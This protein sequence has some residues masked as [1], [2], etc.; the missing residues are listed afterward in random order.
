MKLEA[1]RILKLAGSMAGLLPLPHTD[2]L[3]LADPGLLFE[4]EPQHWWARRI[5]TVVWGRTA[6]AVCRACAFGVNATRAALEL[7]WQQCA[8]FCLACPGTGG[9]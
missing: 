6:T 7:C 1:A 2:V 8:D 4:P 3:Q 9:V 5:A